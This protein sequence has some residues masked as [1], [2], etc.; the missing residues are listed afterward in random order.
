MTILRS[1][2]ILLGSLILIGAALPASGGEL[3]RG[4]GRSG[5]D[6]TEALGGTMP[7]PTNVVFVASANGFK[8]VPAVLTSGR[9]FFR[10]RISMDGDALE[11]ELHYDLEGP[12]Q[13]AWL[14][15]GQPGVSGEPAAK[16]CVETDAGDGTPICPSGNNGMVTGALM[17]EDLIPG[18]AA[19]GVTDIE[20]LVGAMLGRIV[21]VNVFSNFYPE[22]GEVRGNIAALRTNNGGPGGPGGGSNDDWPGDEQ[23]E[24]W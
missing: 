12:I 4:L 19:Q 21:Y 13:K 10:A 1:V 15:I 22:Y 9:A 23:V 6:W 3:H 2:S 5:E 20:S 11:Y 17:T 24:P 18:A 16:L 8:Q 14:Q 7:M